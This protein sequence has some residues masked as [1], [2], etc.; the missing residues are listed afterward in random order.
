[1]RAG[2][3]ASTVTPGSAAPEVSLTSPAIVP[4]LW[5]A[6][7]APNKTHVTKTAL[8]GMSNRLMT[9]SR[10]AEAEHRLRSGRILPQHRRFLRV[11]VKGRVVQGLRQYGCGHSG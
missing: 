3:A 5:P 2:L 7:G 10:D 8:V 1:M 11:A 9:F 4:V 6:S